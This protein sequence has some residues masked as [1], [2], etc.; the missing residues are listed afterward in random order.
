MIPLLAA[1]V[2]PVMS[3]LLRI[4]LSFIAPL[5]SHHMLL[6]SPPL[7]YAF[8]LFQSVMMPLHNVCPLPANLSIFLCLSTPLI[9]S[10]PTFLHLHHLLLHHLLLIISHPTFLHLHHVIHQLQRPTLVVLDILFLFPLPRP[11]LMLPVLLIL[12]IM[13]SRV[14]FL[15]RHRLIHHIIY[16]I[17]L[18][19]SLLTSWD[20]HV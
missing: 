1:Y 19:F 10:H 9:I 12:L 8:F 13:M 14:L 20:I 11:V 5:Q 7:L 17:M 3:P 6:Q 16:G 4:V 2:S 15:M 18:L